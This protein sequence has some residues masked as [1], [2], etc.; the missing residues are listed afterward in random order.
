MPNQE[1]GKKTGN[2]SWGS[3]SQILEETRIENLFKN[4]QNVQDRTHRVRYSFVLKQKTVSFYSQPFN[5]CLQ[6]ILAFKSIIL[7]SL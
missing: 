3:D 6:I 2:I 7:D 4:W 5:S 1:S